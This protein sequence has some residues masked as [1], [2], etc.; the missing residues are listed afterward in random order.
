MS[1]DQTAASSNNGAGVRP[2]RPTFHYLRLL[3]AT[4]TG[5]DMRPLVLVALATI[6]VGSVVFWLVEGWSFLDAVYF[7]IIT[8]STVGYGD[9]APQTTLGK[10]F[11]ILYVLVG[12]GLLGS[13]ISIAARRTSE[14]TINDAPD[15]GESGDATDRDPS[16]LP[17]P[18]AGGATA[19]GAAAGSDARSVPGRSGRPPRPT[20]RPRRAPARPKAGSRPAHPPR[21]AAP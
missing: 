6:V 10:L 17:A 18:R 3:W 19:S 11:T 12:V 8:L 1:D 20:P 14:R 4:I 16:P 21:R 15:T 13:F 5:P 7:S 9:L 2:V